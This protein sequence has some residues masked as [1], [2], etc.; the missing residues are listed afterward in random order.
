MSVKLKIKIK[1][2]QFESSC[3]R[4]EAKKQLKIHRSEYGSIEE[5]G[6]LKIRPED[7]YCGMYES[8]DTHRRTV[9][10]SASR[11]NLLAYGFIRGIPY[12]AMERKCSILPDFKKVKDIARKFGPSSAL[13]A[14]F[15]AWLLDAA[16]HIQSNG[17]EIPFKVLEVKG[18]VVVL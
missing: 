8:L 15:D 13:D 4:S 18:N 9:V 2:L 5:P 7:S 10:R 3:I 12:S 17:M 6:K 1:T 16:T 11:I 14:K